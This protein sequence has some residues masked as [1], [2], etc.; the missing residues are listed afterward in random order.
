[1]DFSAFR[2][3]QIALQLDEATLQAPLSKHSAEVHKCRVIVGLEELLLDRPFVGRSF[4][5]RAVLKVHHL[6]C[7]VLA[8]DCQVEATIE[9]DEINIKSDLNS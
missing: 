4:D 3:S 9:S 8:G 6:S 7:Y 2:P 1:M 5:D